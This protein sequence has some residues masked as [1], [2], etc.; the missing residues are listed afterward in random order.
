[1]PRRLPVRPAKL[2]GNLFVLIVLSL[3][4]F[5]Y[6]AYVIV[7][8][9]PRAE[10]KCQHASLQTTREFTRYSWCTTSFS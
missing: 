10:S 8:W 3:I 5:I 9:G 7:V 6:Y 2:F 1:M 4:S